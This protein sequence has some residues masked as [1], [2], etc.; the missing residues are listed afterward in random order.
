MSQWIARLI[1]ATVVAVMVMFS[2]EDAFA[3]TTIAVVSG[4]IVIFLINLQILR[5]PRRPRARQRTSEAGKAGR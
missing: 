2:R 4:A 3:T 5:G 1:G